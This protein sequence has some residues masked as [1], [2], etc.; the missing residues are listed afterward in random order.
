[1][2][3]AHELIIGT[4]PRHVLVL[5]G[6]FG[7]ERIFDALLPALNTELLSYCCVAY[8][9]Y[10]ASTALTGEYNLDEIASDALDTVGA[11][12]WAQF[13]VIGHS[14]GAKAAQKLML[15][16]PEQVRR[17]VAIT[18]VPA[19]AVPFDDA[20]WRLFLMVARRDD[21]FRQG[22]SKRADAI[23]SPQRGHRIAVARVRRLRG[24]SDRVDA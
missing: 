14:M 18:P 5:H 20:S 1:M 10:G 3:L 22:A 7:H 4:G 23:L 24:M 17:I 19:A 16:A 13:D 12:G 8:R 6:W 15:R 2:R 21:D 11:I 9:G